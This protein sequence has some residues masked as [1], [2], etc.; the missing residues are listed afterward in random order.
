MWLY[1]RELRALYPL[2]DDGF[3]RWCCSTKSELHVQNLILVWQPVRHWYVNNSKKVQDAKTKKVSFYS[4]GKPQPVQMSWICWVNRLLSE[5]WNR[6]AVVSSS[7]IWQGYFCRMQCLVLWNYV[8]T[9][10][11]S[12]L[13]VFFFLV[14][15]IPGWLH[16]LNACLCWNML[17]ALLVS[18]LRV[19]FSK[20]NPVRPL[21]DCFMICSQ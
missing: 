20:R 7:R 5:C 3:A 1:C 8:H 9:V 12:G 11:I 2:Q 10:C 18:H 6:G 21:Q 16:G 17:F 14:E 19:Q 15:L 13:V 4:C